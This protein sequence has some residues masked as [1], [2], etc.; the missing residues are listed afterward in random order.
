MVSDLKSDLV[1]T[2]FQRRPNVHLMGN[3]A[4]SKQ[5]LPGTDFLVI[6]IPCFCGG[7]NVSGDNV[8]HL[9]FM[10]DTKRAKQHKFKWYQKEEFTS[11]VT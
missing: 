4:V 3:P 8:G 5:E 7:S 11:S 2:T 10:R 1:M 9:L 6:E